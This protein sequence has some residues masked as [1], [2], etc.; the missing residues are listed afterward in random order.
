MSLKK[1]NNFIIE[2]SEPKILFR[3]N[4][5]IVHSKQKT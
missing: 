4:N 1:Y 2:M 3:N 5:E